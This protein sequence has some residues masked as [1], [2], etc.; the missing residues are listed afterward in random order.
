MDNV[1]TRVENNFYNKISPVMNSFVGLGNR[2]QFSIGLF[3]KLGVAFDFVQND[4]VEEMESKKEL[5]SP[6]EVVAK[7]LEAFVKIG[8]NN[9]SKKTAVNIKLKYKNEDDLENLIQLLSNDDVLGFLSFVYLH[10][11]Q[12]IVRKHTTKAFV[13]LMQNTVRNYKGQEAYDKMDEG[14]RFKLFNIAEDYAINQSLIE[15]I[16]ASNSK[17]AFMI[18]T[19]GGLFNAEYNGLSEIDILKKLLDDD[20]VMKNLT[21]DHNE[22]GEGG[23]MGKTLEG[24]ETYEDPNGGDKSDKEGDGNQKSSGTIDTSAIDKEIDSLGESISKHIEQQR[25]K[26]GFKLS[27]FI[28]GMVKVDV[29]WFNRLQQGLY[30]FINKKTRHSVASWS[31]IDSKLRHIYKSPKRRNI[32]R[33][34]DIII[35]IDQSGS[36][37]DESLKKLVYLINQKSKNI[38]SIDLLFH[39]TKVCHVESFSGRFNPNDIEKA[40]RKIHCRGGTSHQD[41]FQWLDDNVSARDAKQKIYIS[42]S[43]NYSDIEEVYGKHNIIKRISKVWLNSDGR[44]LDKVPGLQVQFS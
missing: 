29:A 6:I 4:S 31:N 18:K 14:S 35:S 15:V 33:T 20:E 3:L 17:L 30:T 9:F 10:E 8:D 34:V 40:V 26:T 42:F 7:R 13:G 39:D 38:N 24:A 21:A 41:V 22:V 28:D 36:V 23:R 16:E 1:N 37:T 25:G 2:D 19:S 43:D 5:I 44:E 12:H 27:D 32:E 11:T